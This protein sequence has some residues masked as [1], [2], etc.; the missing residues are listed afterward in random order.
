MGFQTNA[1]VAMWLSI[2]LFV[3]TCTT[4]FGR[5]ELQAA[6][7][8]N[9]VVDPWAILRVYT[10]ISAKVGDTITF[11]WQGEHSVW[12]IPS[13]ICPL[14]YTNGVGGQI[15]LA[16]L[17]DGGNYTTPALTAGTKWFVCSAPFHCVLGQLLRVDVA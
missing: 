17:A 2:V 9:H 5:R 10:P 1:K 12:E 7:S 8:T 4:S 16:A 3:A 14:V 15:E 6:A 11:K 13:G